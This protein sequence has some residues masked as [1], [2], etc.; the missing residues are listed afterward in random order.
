MKQ[1]L[2][3][4]DPAG[5]A[6]FFESLGEKP[7]RAR[8]MLR[9]IHRNG[10][11]DFA[12]MSDL[13]RPLREKLAAAAC[14]EAPAIV[15]DSVAEDGTRKWLVKVDR[16][17]AVESVFIP[18]T[19][20][21]TLCVSSQAGCVLDCAFCATGKQGFNRNL[22]TAEIIGQLDRKSTRLN[23]S[24]IQKSRMPSSA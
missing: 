9:W 15:G 21:G 19:G 3:D 1:N 4:L 18:E 11:A 16:S 14:I 6:G 23:S 5:L 20:R 10:E 13:A 8:Q 7:F 24:H 22:S 12:R 2:L 17:N